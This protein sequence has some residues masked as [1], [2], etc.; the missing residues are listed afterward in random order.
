MSQRAYY[1][2]WESGN[3]GRAS[4][5][6]GFSCMSDVTGMVFTW[7]LLQDQEN[8]SCSPFPFATL[9]CVTLVAAKGYSYLKYVTAGLKCFNL[10]LFTEGMKIGFFHSL[11]RTQNPSSLKGQ[12]ARERQIGER[13]QTMLALFLADFRP[14]CFEER[15]HRGDVSGRPSTRHDDSSFCFYSRV[16]MEHLT[17]FR[18]RKQI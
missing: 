12:K 13:R 6:N 9:E 11:L 18:T 5:S 15:A 1:S 7:T 14:D 4:C 16:H 17:P 3:P 8:S 2:M 10:F